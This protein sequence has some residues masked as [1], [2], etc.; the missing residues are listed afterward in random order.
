MIDSYRNRAAILIGNG[1]N[2]LDSGQSFS[3]KELLSKL[4]VECN[5][6]T[7]LENP[8]KPFPLAF[9]EML[10]NK[11]GQKFYDS[12]VRFLK[13]KIHEIFLEIINKETGYNKYHEKISSLPYNDILTTNYDYSIENSAL[14]SFKKSKKELALNR[15]ERKYSLKRGYSIRNKKIWHIHGELY[16]TRN[17]K[18]D[19][20][21][22]NEESIMIGFEHYASYLQRI[23]ENIKGKAGSQKIENQSLIVRLKDEKMSPFWTD[24]FF[25][26]NIDILGLGLDFTENHLWW[27]INYRSNMIRKEIPVQGINVNNNINYYYPRIS[28]DS[29][30]NV[31]N[32]NNLDEVL[33]V[34][35]KIQKTIAIADLLNAF[36]VNTIEIEATSYEDFYDK[37]INRKQREFG[38]H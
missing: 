29:I 23:Q 3:W 14:S 15:L 25:T 12:K 22:Y 27:L 18:D 17:Y 32:L 34:K 28:K 31:M 20:I 2:L 36:N 26:H 21:F 7:D 37:F 4:K 24:I 5:I 8:F 6:T 30:L 38:I 19:S 11:P 10:C 1:I 35:M 9:E 33:N 16:D 13:E